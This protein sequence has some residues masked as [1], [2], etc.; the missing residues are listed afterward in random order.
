MSGPKP[1]QV[2][3]DRNRP[4]IMLAAE[5]L[6][7]ALVVDRAVFEI[8]AGGSTIYLAQRAARV[9]SVEDDPDW[10]AAVRE[11]LDELGLDADMRLVKTQDIASALD[12]AGMWDVVFVDC[13]DQAQRALVMSK[14]AAHTVPGGWLVADDYDFPK[15]RA[16][17]DKLSQREWDIAILSGRKLHPVKR[18]IVETQT[19]FCCRRALA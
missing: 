6:L 19:A 14:A 1:S 17:V 11:R 13:R 3:S 4:I 2:E 5:H 15:V 8:G 7:G 12:D 10:Y 16:A 18:K 9:V